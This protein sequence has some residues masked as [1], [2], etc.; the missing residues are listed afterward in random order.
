[1]GL[2]IYP[3]EKNADE[4]PLFLISRL[5]LDKNEKVSKP[6]AEEVTRRPAHSLG[7]SLF[8]AVHSEDVTALRLDFAQGFVS[9]S[10]ASS[11]AFCISS[12]PASVHNSHRSLQQIV[13]RSSFYGEFF[14][15]CFLGI[16]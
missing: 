15:C 11:H 12:L 4:F 1:V 6:L 8:L 10:A 5:P 2:P 16:L 13:A 7:L 3:F 14:F 9:R